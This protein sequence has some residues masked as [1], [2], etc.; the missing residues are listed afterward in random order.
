MR[1]LDLL[2][3]LIRMRAV[4]PR[5]RSRKRVD[6]VL[7]FMRRG[8]TDQYLRR[9]CCALQ[10]LAH[11]T[12]ICGQLH[13]V[14][15]LLVRLGKGAATRAVCEDLGRLLVR[16]HLDPQIEVAGAVT[17]CLATSVEVALRFAQ[18]MA[19]PCA[20]W[21][22]CSQYNSEGYLLACV[23]FLNTP[24]GQ[25]DHG[26]GLP[27]RQLAQRVSDRESDQL[28][29][30]ASP[31]VQAALASTFRASAASSLPVERAFAETKRNEA[32]RLC[33][34]ST[35]GRNQLIKQF[36]RQRQEVLV[37]AA[38]SAEA[39]RRAGRLNLQSLAWQM[40]PGNIGQ[41]SDMRRFVEEHAEDL[42]E[43]LRRQ[44]A[45]A[46]SHAKPL[47]LGGIPVAESEWVQWFT[48]HEEDFHRR[49]LAAPGERKRFNYR[50]RPAPDTPAPFP[51]LLP[52]RRRPRLSALE[53]WQRLSWGR[54]GWFCASLRP[55]ATATF[56][57]YDFQ[58]LTYLADFSHL[59]AGTGYVLDPN[60]VAALLGSVRPLERA[61]WGDHEVE[62]IMQVQISATASPEGVR[63]QVVGAKVLTE[64]L[65]APKRKI[66][67]TAP[68]ARG[69][70]TAPRAR[71]A[72][73]GDSSG[74]EGLATDDELMA[75]LEVDVRGSD[76]ESSCPS[77]DTEGDS[78]LDDFLVVADDPAAAPD[79]GASD[80]EDPDAVEPEADEGAAAL[81]PRH[82]AGTWVVWSHTWVYVTKTPGYRDVKCCVRGPL[83]NA[84]TGLGLRWLSKTLTPEHFDESWEDPR[85]SL[86]LLRSW[87]V[88][89][90]QQNGW[91]DARPCRRREL[92]RLQKNL[93]DDLRLA[94]GEAGAT[95]PLFGCRKA[96]A[97][98]AAWVP[99]IVDRL[100]A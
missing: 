33:Q 49:M 31:L 11:V 52:G 21:R 78:G 85:R 61:G 99:T 76:G 51:R 28:R 91:A 72:G 1:F 18:Y 98:F 59:R 96:H 42:A 26:F 44:R 35:A 24:E 71:D 20:G 83:R 93:E 17:L 23:D 46:A 68:S 56:F 3:D 65:P 82:A 67:K 6:K 97:L 12:A 57:L 36:L 79:A 81:L 62:E 5:E 94:L 14:E 37:A 45:I 32:P 27:L 16:F 54:S 47:V 63:L 30:L 90:V 41:A 13:D 55:K 8:D 15:P 53:R 10:I 4:Q 60:G 25:L 50:L 77:V 80:L 88:W 100:L 40:N 75:G 86:L 70:A 39:L 22:L 69:S 34:V 43:E 48:D 19:W 9:T 92:A 66:R 38:K 95:R 87:V 2:P 29:W 58:G 7:A 84:E 73:S 89:R 74:S 64:P